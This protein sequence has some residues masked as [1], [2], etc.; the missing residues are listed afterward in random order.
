MSGLQ[1]PNASHHSGIWCLEVWRSLQSRLKIKDTM[2]KILLAFLST[3]SLS[4]FAAQPAITGSNLVATGKTHV[5]SDASSGGGGE[6]RRREV[7]SVQVVDGNGLAT[8]AKCTLTNDKGDWSTTAPG[9]VT[10]LRSAGDLTVVCSKDGNDTHTLVVSAGTTQIQPKHFR[11]QADSDDS[12]DPITVPYY[13]AT[14]TLNLTAAGTPQP[15]P[16][17]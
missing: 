6:D 1:A 15:S 9:T 10:V 12:D 5:I 2:K 14:V 4:A 8:S 7:L 16:S 13:T 11:F 3:I 17:N